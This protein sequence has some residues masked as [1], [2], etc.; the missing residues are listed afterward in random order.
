MPCRSEYGGV[1][2]LVSDQLYGYVVGDGY[3]GL[4]PGQFRRHDVT[5]KSF[6]TQAWLW[7]AG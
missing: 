3:P 6:S 4:D 1:A 7:T 5:V 2:A